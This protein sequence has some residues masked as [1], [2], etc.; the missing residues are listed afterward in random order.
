MIVYDNSHTVQ[1]WEVGVA[2]WHVV[3]NEGDTRGGPDR[4][5]AWAN[6]FDTR[7]DAEHACR[8]LNDRSN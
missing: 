4:Q 8:Y 2:L 1:R 5:G 3:D 7:L 6:S